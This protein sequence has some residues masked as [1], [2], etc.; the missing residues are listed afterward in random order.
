MLSDMLSDN[1]ANS[2]L[3]KK[4]RVDQRLGDNG[5]RCSDPQG[6]KLKLPSGDDGDTDKDGSHFGQMHWGDCI[7]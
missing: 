4:R 5:M 3:S 1:N 7:C 2:C 6:I